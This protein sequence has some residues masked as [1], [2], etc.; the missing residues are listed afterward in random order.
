MEDKRFY[1]TVTLIEMLKER[2]AGKDMEDYFYHQA[3]KFVEKLKQDLENH[4]Y[5]EKLINNK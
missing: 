4:E 5:A 2:W 1:E 3:Q